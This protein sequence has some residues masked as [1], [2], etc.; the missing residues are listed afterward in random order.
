VRLSFRM[1]NSKTA[2]LNFT[3]YFVHVCLWPWLGHPLT[4]L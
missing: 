4:A 2:R 1:H 3:K